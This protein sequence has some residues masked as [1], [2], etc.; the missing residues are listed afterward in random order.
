MLRLNKPATIPA[1]EG[2]RH[3]RSATR[4]INNTNTISGE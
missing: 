4:N 2:E 1:V 3:E